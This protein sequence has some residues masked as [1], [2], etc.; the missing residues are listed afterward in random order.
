MIERDRE[1]KRERDIERDRE[2]GG[3]RERHTHAAAALGN[4]LVDCLCTL[5]EISTESEI[6]RAHV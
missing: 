1:G 3:G 5:P 6:G 4:P 2:R